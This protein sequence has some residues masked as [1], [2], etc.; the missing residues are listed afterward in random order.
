MQYNPEKKGI[1]TR[2]LADFPQVLGL[3]FFLTVL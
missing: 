2:L 3:W 1:L